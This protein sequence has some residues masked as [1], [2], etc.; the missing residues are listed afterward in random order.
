MKIRR[1]R[2]VKMGSCFR[3]FLFSREGKKNDKN[4]KPTKPTIEFQD[5][6]RNRV[7][8]SVRRGAELFLT[9]VAVFPFQF[10][11]VVFVYLLGCWQKR[12]SMGAVIGQFVTRMGKL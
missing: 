8:G 11:S 9:V 6:K 2:A 5:C 10:K 3:F 4:D 1:Q 7:E 12:D